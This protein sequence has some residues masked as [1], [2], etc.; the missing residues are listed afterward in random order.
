MGRD[1]QADPFVFI[2]IGMREFV[3]SLV[4]TAEGQ[5]GNALP[6]WVTRGHGSGKLSER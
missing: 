1:V 3:K 2:G 4:A 6:V 5:M